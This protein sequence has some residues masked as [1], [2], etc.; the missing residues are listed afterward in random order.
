VEAQA[1]AKMMG[2]KVSLWTCR[3]D[4]ISGLSDY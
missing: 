2:Y 3:E 4:I 1:F